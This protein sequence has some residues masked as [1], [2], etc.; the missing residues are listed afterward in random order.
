MGH[1]SRT[2]VLRPCS[3]VRISFEDLPV[4]ILDPIVE[5]LGNRKDLRTCTLVSKEFNRIAT[6]LLYQSLDSRS[7]S[8]VC[9]DYVITS[10]TLRRL[11]SC[12]VL[13]GVTP[14]K[15]L[16][17]RFLYPMTPDGVCSMVSH[18]SLLPTDIGA[19]PLLYPYQ[20]TRTRSVRSRYHGIG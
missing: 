20:T 17:T 8:K 3:L 14:S 2:K 16:P 9:I 18:P 11:V 1:R 12:Q 4:D 7:T 6:P 5:Q 15:Y 19:P 13:E 10:D